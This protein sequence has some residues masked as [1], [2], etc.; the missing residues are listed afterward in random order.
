MK[1]VQLPM[2]SM[3]ALIQA[4]YQ[5]RPPILRTIQIDTDPDRLEVVRMEFVMTPELVKAWGDQCAEMLERQQSR[6]NSQT[7]PFRPPSEK[8]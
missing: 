6:V 1:Y 2:T 7:P 8:S 4:V 5:V 3:Q